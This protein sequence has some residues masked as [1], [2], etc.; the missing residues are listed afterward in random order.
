MSFASGFYGRVADNMQ[1]KKQFI[2]QRVEEDRLYLRQQGL[3]RQ[4]AVTEQKTR[5]QQATE[6]LMRIRGVD[7]DRVLAALEAD[8]DG[9]LDLANRDY[10]TGSEINT[11]LEIYGDTEASGSL[12]DILG[13]VMPAFSALPADADPTTVKRTGIAAWLGLDTET[14]LNEQVYSAQIVGGMTGDQI[15]A[16]MNI[17][18]TAQGTGSRGMNYEAVEELSEPQRQSHFNDMI[19]EYDAMLEAE[20][21]KIQELPLSDEFTAADKMEQIKELRDLGT[22]P[23]DTRLQKLLEKFGPTDNS[24]A[25]FDRFGE[26]LF[27]PGMARF[28][29]ATQEDNPEDTQDPN[30]ITT[31]E[32]PAAPVEVT[33]DE[34]A[35]D[36]MQIAKANGETSITLIQDGVE[37]TVDL[38]AIEETD[39]DIVDVVIDPEEPN[40]ITVTTRRGETVTK[41]AHP[42]FI[43]GLRLIWNKSGGGTSGSGRNRSNERA[44]VDSANPESTPEPT[45]DEGPVDTFE[46]A[47]PLDGMPNQPRSGPSTRPTVGRRGPSVA[48]EPTIDEGPV[49][50]F[51]SALPLDGMSSRQRSGP[52]TRPIVGRREPSV[53]PRVRPEYLEQKNKLVTQVERLGDQR[54]T[55]AVKGIDLS[56]SGRIRR[57]EIDS[58]VRGLRQ[59]NQTPEVISLIEALMEMRG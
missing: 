54:L 52:S 30:V 35:L 2:R 55:N 48:P 39:D 45:V 57:R 40:M 47:L 8:P 29:S 22:G 10:T 23:V 53:A 9:I 12:T 16:S 19:P 34:E 18:V 20:I 3:Q 41:E 43:D 7:K 21:T 24:N 58:I 33:S 28:F 49:D 15:L 11:V 44:N 14:E 25:F 36:A 38:T 17:P 13:K 32:L 51:E 56:A 1:D 50:T 42:T 27:G 59:R 46:S 5:Y 31:T 26:G 4:A 6:Q 37:S